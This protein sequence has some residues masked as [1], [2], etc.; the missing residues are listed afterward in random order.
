MMFGRPNVLKIIAKILIS[1]RWHRWHRLMSRRKK[2]N[3]RNGT[4]NSIAIDYSMDAVIKY[5][6]RVEV[7]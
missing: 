7:H 3:S 6:I 4:Y 1:H 2:G 5:V